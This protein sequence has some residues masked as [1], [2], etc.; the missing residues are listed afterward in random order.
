MKTGT[1][2]FGNVALILPDFTKSIN[3]VNMVDLPIQFAY[4]TKDWMIGPEH[5]KNVKSRYQFISDL[6]CHMPFLEIKDALE[7]AISKYQH[8]NK[9]KYGQVVKRLKC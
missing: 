5:Y 7:E 4:G 9:F 1:G 3:Q 8:V 2:I 6:R